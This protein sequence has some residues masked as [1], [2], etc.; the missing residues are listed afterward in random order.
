MK[1]IEQ[2]EACT[3]P[4]E[5]WTHANHFIMALWY[6]VNFPLPQ[7]VHKIRDGIKTYNV[8]NTE[9]SGYHE[10]ITLFYI[11]TIANY[12]V[13]TGVSSLTDETIA[14][15]L[16]QPF[17]LKEYIFSFYSEEL[18]KSKEARKHWMAPDKIL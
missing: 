14:A 8:N 11:H 17:I 7:A 18:L 12:I 9:Y 10:T 4:K 3:L 5:E 2:F 16:Q 15:F 1:L 6:C 13:A